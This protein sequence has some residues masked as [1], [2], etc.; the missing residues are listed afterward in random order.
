MNS[1]EANKYSM[2]TGT[3]K[4]L[5]NNATKTAAIPAFGESYE[6]FAGLVEQ[7]RDKDKDMLGKT[8]G[9]VAAKEEMGDAMVTATVIIGAGLAA[10]AKK[11]GNTQLKEAIHIHEGRLR[12]ARRSEQINRAKLTYDLA[13]ANEQDLVAFAITS[14]MLADLKSRIAA[15]EEALKDVST[16]VAERSG[17]RSMLSDL[18]IQADEVLKDEMDQM[19][20]VFRTTDPEFYNEYRSARVIK[21]LGVRHNKAGQSAAPAPGS[22]N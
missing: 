20:Q 10:L 4:L 16:S 18:F 19:M 22:P 5:G 8:P 14:S 11:K 13:K 12:S 7:I 15:F 1:N 3:A 21:D 6:K 2:Y 17:A 9:R